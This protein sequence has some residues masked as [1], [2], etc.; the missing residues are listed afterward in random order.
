MCVCCVC[1]RTKPTCCNALVVV[2]S[3]KGSPATHHPS[4][5]GQPNAGAGRR[6]AV[7]VPG[8]RR[9]RAHR[10]LE[11]KRCQPGRE[12]PP[13]LPARARQP[14]D[15][16]HQGIGS[17]CSGWGDDSSLGGCEDRFHC[18]SFCC[19]FIIVFLLLFFFFT[20]VV[21]WGLHSIMN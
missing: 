19:F 12:G 6:V 17:H 11:E 3:P 5:P 21:S 10:H 16:E 7:E 8:V 13:L 20:L 4:G 14:S 9:A 2:F 18:D 1:V 15:P